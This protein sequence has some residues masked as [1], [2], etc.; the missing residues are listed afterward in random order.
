MNKSAKY[1]VY[2]LQCSDN[3]LYVGHTSNLNNRLFWHRSGFA[4]KYT[5]ARLPIK[6]VYTEEHHDEVSAL[7]RENQIKRWSGQKKQA[8]ISGDLGLLKKL[9]KSRD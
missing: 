2:I 5:S 3:T 4:S 6:L 8:L 1:F 9:S 7:K